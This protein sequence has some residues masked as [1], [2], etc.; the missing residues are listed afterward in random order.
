[1]AQQE[2][3]LTSNQERSKYTLIATPP[4][5]QKFATVSLFKYFFKKNFAKY[6]LDIKNIHSGY[7][8]VRSLKM[9]SRA[10]TTLIYN[11]AQKM[12]FS[13]KDFFSKCDQIRRKLQKLLIWLHLLDKSLTKNFI[14]CVVQVLLILT[15][16]KGLPDIFH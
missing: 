11:T 13:I 9:F 15:N 10:N 7:S 5:N 3:T 1:M 4:L 2:P 6:Y 12:K 16:F 8:T 14:F